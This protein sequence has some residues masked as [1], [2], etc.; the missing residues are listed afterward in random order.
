MLFDDAHLPIDHS[1]VHR[2]VHAASVRVVLDGDVAHGL[3]EL[4]ILFPH[5][6]VC[7]TSIGCGHSCV[8]TGC[9]SAAVI[10]ERIAE[11][12]REVEHRE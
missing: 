7:A 4:V 6:I 12:L 5:E 9:A 2:D 1:V 10:A 3:E 8:Y 11:H